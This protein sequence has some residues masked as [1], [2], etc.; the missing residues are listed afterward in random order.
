MRRTLKLKKPDF[1]LS[2]VMLIDDSEM[3]NFINQN[4]I[5]AARFSERV[6][7]TTNGLSALEFLN[8]LLV[9]KETLQT[10][11]PEIIF[12]DLNMPLMNGFQFI[13]KF[14]ELPEELA[15][16]C[17]IVILTSSLNPSDQ[18]TA[19]KINKDIV[20]LHKPLTA[21]NLTSIA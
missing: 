15:G 17:K 6:Y 13:K 11:V 12:V 21:T 5:E 3:D 19:Q 1:R 7:T 4:V 18:E 16:A 20:F 8:N 10:M 9:N 2:N 14:Y